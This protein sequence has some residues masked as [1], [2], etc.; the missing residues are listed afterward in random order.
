MGAGEIRLVA[1]GVQDMFLTDDP[2]ITY[3]KII[4]R[5]HTNFSVEQMPQYFI[6]KPDFGK[7]ATCIVSRNGDLLGKGYLVIDTPK[8]KK[9]MIDGIEDPITKF[10]WVR[11]LGYAMNG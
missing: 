9:F 2:Q 1:H 7:R 10:A 5:R 8:I 6:H 3:F 4:Y 11:R